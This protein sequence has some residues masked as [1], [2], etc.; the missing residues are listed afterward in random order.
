[1]DRIID[2]QSQGSKSRMGFP[3]S[4]VLVAFALGAS[5]NCWS[6]DL[7][8]FRACLGT[9]G[10]GS[11]CALDPGDWVIDS[12]VRV[13]R[14]NLTVTGIITPDG[15]RPTLRR[16]VGFRQEMVRISPQEGQKLST[17]TI[18]ELVFDGNRGRVGA[19]PTEASADVEVYSTSNLLFHKCRFVDAQRHHLVLDAQSAAIMVT[20][21][22]FDGAAWFG[23]WSDSAQLPRPGRSVSCEDADRAS[24]LSDLVVAGNRFENAGANAL[25]LHARNVQVIGNLFRDNHRE[26]PFNISGGQ[27]DILQ[28]SNN[29]AFHRNRF[30][31]GRM[32]ANGWWADGFEVY[33]RNVAFID[34][35]AENNA[36]AAGTFLGLEDAFFAHWDPRTAFRGN[37]LGGPFIANSIGF[38]PVS[39]VH[40]DRVN[41]VNN[42]EGYGVNLD[43]AR[44]GEVI[45]GVTLTNNCVAGNREPF[46]LRGL[47]RDADVRDNRTSNCGP[48]SGSVEEYELPSGEV[49]EQLLQLSGVGLNP[50]ALRLIT[51]RGGN[52]ITVGAS[53]PTS[54]GLALTV[55]TDTRGL[56]DS[57]YTAEVFAGATKLETL[58]IEVGHGGPFFD[59]G[60]VVNEAS[61]T[62]GPVAPGTLLHIYGRGFGPPFPYQAQFF[63]GLLRTR[64]AA[65]RVLVEGVPAPIYFA[66]ANEVMVSIPDGPEGRGFVGL[67][68]EDIGA[69]TP[70]VRIPIVPAAPVLF[71]EITFGDGLTV[72]EANPVNA[73]AVVAV[74]ATGLGRFTS[75]DAGAWPV[76]PITVRIDGMEAEIL[77]LTRVIAPN[78]GLVS[79]EIRVP[80][81]ISS[82]P[83][84][85]KLRAGTFE[86]PQIP[87]IVR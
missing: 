66:A 61:R 20:D 39:R 87:L 81:E 72:S 47:D 77:K 80:S 51:E 85:V 41:S 32:S 7:T 79:L 60:G 21:S 30:T 33:A 37:R 55:L 27:V 64:L 6:L 2:C 18:R 73:G 44:T 13:E 68:I 1:M 34:N 29:V 84:S 78:S 42:G 38:R 57:R 31:D 71:A 3:A 54:D 43:N 25:F 49:G 19:P 9:T 4:G 16:A 82:G 69:L 24:T 8:G 17:I 59:L 15:T 65:T 83:A 10:Q 12:T 70:M 52:W 45:R 86:S 28:C 26:A 50:S 75:G 40:I 58:S 46:F 36:G 76:L 63:E 67:Q 35:T 5:L 48:E 53:R 22:T 74:R 11:V 62:T 23:I 56:P 14:S